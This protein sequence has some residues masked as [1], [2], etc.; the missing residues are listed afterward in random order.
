M[1]DAPAQPPSLWRQYH[2]VAVA[3]VL[4]VGVTAMWMRSLIATDTVWLSTIDG[5]WNGLQ[6]SNGVIAVCISTTKLG[7]DEAGVMRHVSTRRAADLRGDVAL[8]VFD[9]WTPPAATPAPGA[10]VVLQDT[11]D[12]TQYMLGNEL[13]VQRVTATDA[14]GLCVLAGN[15]DAGRFT[16][17]LFT[18]PYWLIACVLLATFLLR[19]RRLGVMRVRRR[20]GWCLSCGY[21]ARHTDGFC[22][23]CGTQ[24]APSPR[25]PLRWRRGVMLMILIG[26]AVALA[27]VIGRSS[28]VDYA[29]LSRPQRAIDATNP[30]YTLIGQRVS[31]AQL[32]W[33][34][35]QRY[36]VTVTV[37]WGQI[38]SRTFSRYRLMEFN[39][40]DATFGEILEQIEAIDPEQIVVEASGNEVTIGSAKRLGGRT[41]WRA[42]DV[43]RLTR[44]RSRLAE[45]E[46]LPRVQGG[47]GMSAGSRSRVTAAIAE[48][49]QSRVRREQWHTTSAT[50]RSADTVLLIRQTPWAHVRIRGELARLEAEWTQALSV[51]LRPTAGDG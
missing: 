47:G 8:A 3:A 30:R 29:A 7:P 20:R 2:K 32:L 34:V 51:D 28:R 11:L 36:G 9:F 33:F 19:A 16:G 46:L 41:V 44:L 10:R 38:S 26:L 37:N 45:V 23:E 50:V 1:T 25:G 18:V 35:E 22:P 24:N 14:A 12:P 27:Y 21:N 5:Q 40:V 39:A 42:Y 6:S 13:L 49:L 4:L 43:R 48:E 17:L 31:V 15:D